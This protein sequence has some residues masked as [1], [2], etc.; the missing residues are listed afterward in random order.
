[1]SIK[2]NDH[3][4]WSIFYRYI[5]C[6]SAEHNF[7]LAA[8]SKSLRFQTKE[9]YLDDTNEFAH[10]SY[11]RII[12]A[13]DAETWILLPRQLSRW[14]YAYRKL[15][16]NIV[17]HWNKCPNSESHN[18][19]FWFKIRYIIYYLKVKPLIDLSL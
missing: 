9:W 11:R 8:M 16:Q 15:F 3:R 13:L 1:M 19:L 18:H 17:V 4:E 7:G 12:P 5:V 14:S 6:V 10:E 2:L